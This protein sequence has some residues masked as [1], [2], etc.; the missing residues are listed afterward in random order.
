MLE[1]TGCT[2][3]PLAP[4]SRTDTALTALGI[5]VS[6]AVA[7]IG[8]FVILEARQDAWTQASQASE[9][10]RLA[11]ARDI[12][13]NM[14]V[15]DL[16]LRGVISAMAEP[17]IDQASPGVRRQAM[18]DTS[19]T[20]EDLGAIL[21]LNPAG[22]IV[23]ESTSSVP[24]RIDLSDRDYFTVHRDRPD[25]G[26][27]ISRVY[28][29]RLNNGEF[30][31]GLSRRL[32][33]QDGGFAGVVEGALRMSF[34]QRLFGKLD[35]GS[36]GSITLFRDDGWLLAR[37]PFR[38]QDVD[39]NLQQTSSFQS[40]ISADQ[41]K[42]VA[43]ATLDGVERSYN[44]GKIPGLPLILVVGRSTEDIL[45]AWWNRT[46]VLTPVLILLLCAAVL[47]TLLFHR[48]I[49]RRIKTEGLLRKAASELSALATVD[50]LTGIANRRAFDIA[51]DQFWRSAIRAPS[52]WIALLM[53]DVDRFK[54]I[55]D[56]CGHP[57]GDRIL[58]A[59]ASC[60]DSRAGRPGDLCSRYGGEEF[61]VL[62]PD[63]D[64]EG[65]LYVAERMRSAV[66]NL[67]ILHPGSPEGPVTVSIGVAA[68]RPQLGDLSSNLIRTADVA[69]YE[70]KRGGRNRVQS[71][72]EDEQHLRPTKPSVPEASAV[73]AETDVAM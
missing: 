19:A 18:F 3:L 2:S 48:E 28:H 15:I 12:G 31:I 64:L 71:Q 24:H 7:A 33:T 61:A 49:R 65:A 11:L 53:I 23:E 35:L 30:R 27:F 10:L 5:F 36:R 60:I 51:I 37:R 4:S 20:A 62:L 73:N 46:L 38:E 70:A 69:L 14:S 50:A 72:D 25:A 1:F 17:G 45:A 32:S 22:Q 58:R 44:F 8:V 26:P 13:R 29:D 59:V 57:E 40:L 55:N 6:L 67:D 63:T 47:S 52:S 54:T 56:Q 66:S 39:Q 21:I 9:N 16:S 68:F 42:F 43:T 41:G 34:F